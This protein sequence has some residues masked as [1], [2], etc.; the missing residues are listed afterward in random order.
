MSLAWYISVERE[1][2]GLDTFVNGK[3]IAHVSEK[4][5]AAIVGKLGIRPLTDFFS[6]SP[7]EVA[8]LVG[9]S[10]GDA[11]EIAGMPEEQWFSAKEGLDTVRPLLAYLREKEGELDRQE[12]IVSDL[13][14]YE[15][16]L[17][18]LAEEGVR[19]HL[20]IDI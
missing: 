20:S 6:A 15:R 5:L 14:E 2:S 8:D 18:V 17:D 1:I 4:K 9:E 3:S 7:D 11:G 16:I 13:E 12:Y 10:W 19:W